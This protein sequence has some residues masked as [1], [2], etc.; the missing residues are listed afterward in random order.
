[1]SLLGPL[2]SRVVSLVRPHAPAL[3]VAMAL[4]GVVAACRGGLVWLVRDV[5]DALLDAGD[6]RAATVLP[7][8]P[9]GRNS[10]WS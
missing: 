10:W 5:L 6:P 4:A 2:A 1:M 8:S 7:R 9:R 3:V